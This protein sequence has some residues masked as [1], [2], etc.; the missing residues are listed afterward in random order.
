MTPF[1]V[2]LD[3]MKMAQEM[4]E[5][6][7]QAEEMKFLTKLQTLRDSNA[8]INDINSFVDNSSPKRYDSNTLV[9]RASSLYNFVSTANTKK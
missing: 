2:R 7:T 6:E 4:L 1:E 5:R 8:S 9:A 3:V